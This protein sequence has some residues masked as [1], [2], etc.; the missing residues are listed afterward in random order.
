MLSLTRIDKH[1]L[2]VPYIL[3]VWVQ[4]C[5]FM[6]RNIYNDI[7]LSI[8]LWLNV[9]TRFILSIC[10]H[11]SIYSSIHPSISSSIYIYSSIHPTIYPNQSIHLYPSMVVCLSYFIYEL[12]IKWNKLLP[13]VLIFSLRRVILLTKL[14]WEFPFLL[15]FF[16]F[17]MCACMYLE[18]RSPSKTRCFTSQRP[19]PLLK[20][21]E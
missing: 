10:I 9:P 3:F 21:L 6:I 13:I 11:P 18:Q 20:L 15:F 2:N 16:F 1:W 4:V 19:N 14:Y 12:T 5:L 8:N 7:I 17:A